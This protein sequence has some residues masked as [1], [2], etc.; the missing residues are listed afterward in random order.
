MKKKLEVKKKKNNLPYRGVMG[1][2]FGID[3][4]PAYGLVSDGSTRAGLDS[5]YRIY[6]IRKK[7]IVVSRNIGFATNNLTEYFGL[8]H[9]VKMCVENNMKAVYT[10]SMVALSW[11]CSDN[12]NTNFNFNSNPKIHDILQRVFELKSD[13]DVSKINKCHAMVNGSVDVLFW[14]K[15]RWG[16]NPAD[17]GRK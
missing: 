5:E 8:I 14:N 9:A 11:F 4:P 3:M 2:V 6:D 12:P 16:E 1:N 13:W 15:K 10:D 17:F 7:E